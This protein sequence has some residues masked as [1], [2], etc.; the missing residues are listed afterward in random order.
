MKIVFLS[1]RVDVIES[2]NETRDCLDKNWIDLCLQLGFIAIPIPNNKENLQNLLSQITPEA[3]ILTGGVSPV[4]HGG[5]SPQRDEVDNILIQYSI[6]KNIPLLG[7]CRGMQSIGLYFNCELKEVDNHI[8]KNHNI[9][10]KI[11]DNVNS[12]H[13]LSISNIDE[14]I[15]EILA[16]SDDN[17]I[18]SIKHKQ[19][20]ILGIMWHPERYSPFRDDDIKLIKEF[21]ER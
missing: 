14:N 5:F 3:I 9:S 1:Q 7:V 10:G 15:F 20:N 11:N 13:S 21:L 19:E 2:Y 16:K 12:F 17:V 18:E 8:A 4:K 6:D